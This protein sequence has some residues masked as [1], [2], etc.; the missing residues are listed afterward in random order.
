LCKISGRK[1]A[2]AVGSCTDAL[3]FALQLAG[4]E[5]G[6]EVLVTCFSYIAS[7]SPILRVGAIPVFVDI[8]K[9]SFMMDLNDLERKITNKTKAIL[10]VHQFGQ[11]LPLA[12]LEALAAKYNLIII[13]DVAQAFGCRNYD[14]P[15]GNIGIASCFS[16]DPTKIIGAF[17][18]AGALAT[19]DEQIYNKAK[20]LRFH[21]KNPAT[22]DFEMPGYNSQIASSQAAILTLSETF[23]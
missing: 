23:I 4:I 16:F 1:Y 17:G 22:G 19:D 21:G 14:H 6:D 9:E 18:T 3:Y 2:V 7:V 5:R 12:H 11:S 10:A 20:K 13:E 8:D 15:A